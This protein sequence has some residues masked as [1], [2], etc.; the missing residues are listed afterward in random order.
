MSSEKSHK[1]ERPTQ[2]D[3]PEDERPT[4]DV[5]EEQAPGAGLT[6]AQRRILG[7]VLQGMERLAEM[8][9]QR[10][11]VSAG[12]VRFKFVRVLEERS[13]GMQVLL[14]E[15]HLRH[16]LAGYVVIKRLRNPM[17]FARRQQLREEVQLAFRLHHPAIAQVHHFAVFDRKPHVVMEYVDGPMFDTLLTMAAMQGRAAPGAP[18]PLRAGRGSRC[19]ALTR[20]R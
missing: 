9:S 7:E 14:F 8:I 20:T 12:P 11:R 2:D 6:P 5:N 18:C 17:T 3:V 1:D 19:A 15:R 13:N 10:D 16:G 4:V